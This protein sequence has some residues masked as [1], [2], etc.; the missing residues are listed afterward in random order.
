M[1]FLP[2]MNPI[3]ITAAVIPAVILLVQVYKADKLD[4]E[5]PAMLVSL[6]LF[7]ILSTVAAGLIEGIG[8]RILSLFLQKDSLLYNAV[9]YFGI[10]AFAEEGSK[11]F[12]L[13]RRT[14]NSLNFNCQFDGVVYA[15]FVSLGFALWEN[16]SY[17]AQY[18]LGTALVRA[19]TAVPGHACFGVFMGVWYGLA[20]RYDGLNMH[21]RSAQCRT[22]ALLLPAFMHGVYDFTATLDS[23]QYG[24]IFTAF[25]IVMFL[26]AFRLVRRMS[27]DDHYIATPYDPARFV[28]YDP[29]SGS[30]F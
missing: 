16:I 21:A 24:W 18:G 17:V 11:Y 7:G 26:I 6:V 8:I 3:L 30:G 2:T 1:F 22:S 9:L 14:W 10:V 20:K 23:V 12:L 15:V 29:R 4:K 5:P 27:R 19:V 13:R 28:D 25:V